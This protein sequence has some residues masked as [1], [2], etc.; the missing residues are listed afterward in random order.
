[1]RRVDRVV[2]FAGPRDTNP[3]V[4]TWLSMPS[5]TPIDRFYGFTGTDDPLTRIIRRRST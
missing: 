4:A 5:A 2:S 3:V 1:V